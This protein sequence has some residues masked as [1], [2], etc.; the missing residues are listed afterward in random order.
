MKIAIAKEH[1]G[2]FYV[3][4]LE[5]MLREINFD[6]WENDNSFYPQNG[7]N[8][9]AFESRMRCDPDVLKAVAQSPYTWKIVDV[10]DNIPFKVEEYDGC[11]SVALCINGKIWNDREWDDLDSDEK[12]KLL[13]GDPYHSQD[14]HMRLYLEKTLMDSTKAAAYG[15]MGTEYTDSEMETIYKFIS[16]MTAIP[17]N[18]IRNRI[19]PANKE[20]EEDREEE[21][22]DR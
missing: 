7:E 12:E 16:D 2:G 17:V 9:E 8:Y 4:A 20:E 19:H 14:K 5:H 6:R 10:P 18:D 21:Y 11:E 13:A 22:G 3:P 1:G 15:Y